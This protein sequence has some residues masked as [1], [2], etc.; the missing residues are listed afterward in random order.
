MK[1]S[2]F[3]LCL[4]FLTGLSLTAAGRSPSKCEYSYYK[5]NKWVGSTMIG[6]PFTLNPPGLDPCFKRCLKTRGCNTFTTLV[7]NGDAPNCWLYKEIDDDSK[8]DSQNPRYTRDH[9][10]FTSF[11]TAVLKPCWSV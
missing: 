3:A 4:I 9:S 6:K 1:L 11:A 5:F 8:P 10:G 7:N 2:L